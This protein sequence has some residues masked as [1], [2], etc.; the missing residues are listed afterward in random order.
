MNMISLG[1]DIG[2]TGAKCVA[3]DDHGAQLALSYIEYP[4]PPGK[5]NLEPQV[6]SDSV[7]RVIRDCVQA[8]PARDA[9]AA[10]T[11]SSFG[12]S[13]VLLDK[14]DKILFYPMLYTD[15]RGEEEAEEIL[16]KCGAE[17]LKPTENAAFVRK[18]HGDN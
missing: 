11:V 13:F 5:A 4:N 14:E 12:E 9:V 1:V 8:L 17:Q 7:V 15:P 6:L 3:F 18:E 10:I 16:K 2:G